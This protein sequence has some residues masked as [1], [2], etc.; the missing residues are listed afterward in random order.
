MFFEYSLQEQE[1][2]IVMIISFTVDHGLI[3]TNVLTV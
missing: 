3:R 2:E 1:R